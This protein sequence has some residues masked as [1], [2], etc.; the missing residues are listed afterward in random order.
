[1]EGLD[2]SVAVPPMVQQKSTATM[3][4]ESMK[5]AYEGEFH[6]LP[7]EWHMS[8]KPN[9]K[10]REMA[11]LPRPDHSTGHY[12]EDMLYFQESDN[13]AAI[14]TVEELMMVVTSVPPPH[15][16]F[17]TERFFLFPKDHE[18]TWEDELFMNCGCVKFEIAASRCIDDKVLGVDLWLTLVSL[19]TGGMFSN[20]EERFDVCG[21]RI[22]R[23][24]AINVEFW[25]GRKNIK[26]CSGDDDVAGKDEVTVDSHKNLDILTDDIL[27]KF[28]CEIKRL[29]DEGTPEAFKSAE[30]K[31]S[32]QKFCKSD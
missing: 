24:K 8:W 21:L 12:V 29:M 3:S 20:F 30:M 16:L 27:D 26:E 5:R 25:I 9:R 22:T 7:R 13:K 4:P 14:S 23:K 28:C 17:E 11:P 1:M 18:I 19:T 15:L 10:V 6:L 2:S 31:F 32:T